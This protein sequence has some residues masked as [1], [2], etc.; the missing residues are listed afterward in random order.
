MLAQVR[1]VA[2]WLEVDCSGRD[3]AR[4]LLQAD[5][6]VWQSV[7]FDDTRARVLS[8]RLRTLPGFDTNRLLD[9]VTDTRAGLV[10]IWSAADVLVRR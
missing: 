7:A 5:D 3:T 1:A 9:A 6:M 4:F 2:V 8:A 10:T